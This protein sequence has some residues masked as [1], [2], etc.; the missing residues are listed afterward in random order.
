MGRIYTPGTM[1]LKFWLIAM[2][3]AVLPDISAIFTRFG[4]SNEALLG[5][6]NFTHSLSFALI[7]GFV[8]VWLGFREVKLFS[9]SSISL[10]IFFFICTASHG[11][12]DAMTNGGLGIAFY[13]PFSGERYFLPWTPVD[14]PEIKPNQFLGKWGK[15][16]IISELIWIC[17]PMLVL[18]L[19]VV[20]FRKWRSRQNPILRVGVE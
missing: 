7:T 11:L 13:S 5:H 18:M 3:C 8:A 15:K 17:L 20:G 2:F 10:W 12:L 9:R 19:S 6:R 4:V 16:V 14:M 1:P